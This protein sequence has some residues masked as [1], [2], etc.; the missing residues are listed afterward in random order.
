[1]TWHRVA[2]AKD[3]KEGE[4]MAVEAGG[5]QVALCRV[6]GTIYAFDNLCPHAYALLSDGFIADMEIECPLHTA[7]F[8]IATGRCLA[9]PADSDLDVFS[10]RVDGDNV[11]VEVAE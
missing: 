8:D 3:V 4:A 6:S 7:R 10:V 11:F 2:A 1:M 9:P 5:R